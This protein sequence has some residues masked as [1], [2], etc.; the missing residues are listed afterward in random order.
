MRVGARRR[1]VQTPKTISGVSFEPNTCVVSRHSPSD[2]FFE[3]AET[4]AN[5]LQS[6]SNPDLNLMYVSELLSLFDKMQ[7][8]SELCFQSAKLTK[9]T[10]YIFQ[11]ESVFL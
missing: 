8:S 5:K 10:K 2:H 1:L 6:P 3:I 11:V 7:K 4:L 9:L